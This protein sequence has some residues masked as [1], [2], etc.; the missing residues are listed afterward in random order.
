MCYV[1]VTF[2]TCEVRV[3]GLRCRSGSSLYIYRVYLLTYYLSTRHHNLQ[4]SPE[5]IS[6]KAHFRRKGGV[7]ITYIRKEG[8]K[9]TLSRDDFENSLTIPL[10]WSPTPTQEHGVL[11]MMKRPQDQ[12]V[13]SRQCSLPSFL[14]YIRYTYTSRDV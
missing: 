2:V 3:C 8:R 10:C 9:A 12:G 7:G 14:P 4:I 11:A 13:V 5:E 1:C 6:S